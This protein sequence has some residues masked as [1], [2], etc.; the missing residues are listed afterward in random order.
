[1]FPVSLGC[2]YLVILDRVEAQSLKLTLVPNLLERTSWRESWS[3][4]TYF[5]KCLLIPEWVLWPSRIIFLHTQLWVI[6]GS[7]PFYRLLIYIYIYIYNGLFIWGM[8]PET[9][10]TWLTFDSLMVKPVAPP[11][12]SKSNL[13][14]FLKPLSC[15]CR[16]RPWFHHPT[17]CHNHFSSLG[18]REC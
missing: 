3:W 16:G 8:V 10:T 13:A 9:W 1:M 7:I 15:F 2:P 5:R 17:R 14:R 18:K 4:L 12:S 11:M 6:S